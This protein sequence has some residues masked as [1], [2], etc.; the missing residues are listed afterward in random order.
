[1]WGAW[2]CGCVVRGSSPTAA[3]ITPRAILLAVLLT[4]QKGFTAEDTSDAASQSS[5]SAA[6]QATD[7]ADRR[8]A[9]VEVYHRYDG[10]TEGLMHFFA[11]LNMA[12][13]ELLR[14]EEFLLG[15]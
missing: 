1:M 15:S 7:R 4:A 12:K 6:S 2:V 10:M 8:V 3:L 13:M 5:S 11:V 14:G 9:G